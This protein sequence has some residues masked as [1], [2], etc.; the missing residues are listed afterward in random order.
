MI[1][2]I[3]IIINVIAGGVLFYFSNTKEATGK[4]G[5]L[6]LGA[7]AVLLSGIIQGVVL[8]AAHHVVRYLRRIM[9]ALQQNRG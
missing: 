3:W 8:C 7:A 1:G 6:A 9:N 2:V 4:S 5:W